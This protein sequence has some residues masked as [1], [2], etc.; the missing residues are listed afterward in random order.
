EYQKPKDSIKSLGRL[1]SRFTDFLCKANFLEKR[2]EGE[3]LEKRIKENFTQFWNIFF[4]NNMI[5]IFYPRNSLFN[6]IK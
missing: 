3:I 6:I 1:M 5:F 4:D 2:I